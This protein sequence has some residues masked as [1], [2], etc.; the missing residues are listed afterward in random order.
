MIDA[1]EREDFKNKLEFLLGKIINKCSISSLSESEEQEMKRG[2]YEPDFAEWRDEESLS[3][4]NELDD[5]KTLSNAIEL[6]IWWKNYQLQLQK[7]FQ[8]QKTFCISATSGSCERNFSTA[9]YLINERCIRLLKLMHPY[10]YTT[11][12]K[13]SPNYI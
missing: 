7:I 8:A 3:A 10:L 2:K 1:A 6:N 11:T 4:K 5:L 12:Y 13:T 9:G